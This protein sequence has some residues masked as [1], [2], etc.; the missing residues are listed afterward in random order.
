MNIEIFTDGGARGNPGPAAAGV[1]IVSDPNTKHYGYFLGEMTNNQAEYLALIIALEEVG[2]LQD[3]KAAKIIV[4]MDSELVVKQVTGEYR[5]KD[6][7]L[8]PLYGVVLSLLKSLPVVEFVHIPREKNTAADKIVNR[9]LDVQN[10][11]KSI[12]KTT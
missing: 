2:R 7:G 8:K 4:R 10:G 5:V 9:V 6:L 12:I 1:V 11:I 3:L